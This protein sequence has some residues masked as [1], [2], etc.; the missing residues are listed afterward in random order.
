MELKRILLRISSKSEQKNVLKYF[1]IL[2]VLGGLLP[3]YNY[4]VSIGGFTSILPTPRGSSTQAPNVLGF[5][6][7][8]TYSRVLLVIAYDSG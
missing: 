6:L 7:K 3:A 1:E 4:T 8:P 5:K 2:F